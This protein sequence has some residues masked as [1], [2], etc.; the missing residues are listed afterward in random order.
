M[1]AAPYDTS[2]KA[3]P[4][5]CAPVAGCGGRWAD[6][7]AACAC[8]LPAARSRGVWVLAPQINAQSGECGDAVAVTPKGSK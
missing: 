3:P 7:C 1:S 4:E 2:V 6:A 8:T 5:L